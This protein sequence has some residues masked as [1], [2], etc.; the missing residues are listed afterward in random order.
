MIR[1]LRWKVVAITML[2]VS[3][4]MLAVF[5]GVYFNARTTLRQSAEQQLHQALQMRVDISH[6]IVVFLYLFQ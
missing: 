4:V 6:I 2:F 5:V 1:K 3:A